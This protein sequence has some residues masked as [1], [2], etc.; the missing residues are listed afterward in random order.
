MSSPLL[1]GAPVFVGEKRAVIHAA[2]S[3]IIALA[4]QG[5]LRVLV[6]SGGATTPLILRRIALSWTLDYT[7]T[8]VVSDER[9]SES[10]VELNATQLYDS[11]RST[12]L[13]TAQIVS[14]SYRP[15]LTESASDWSSK[16]A[17]LPLPDAAILSMAD[18][19]HIASLFPGVASEAVSDSVAICRTS[20]KPP[21]ERISLSSAYLR[22][23][24]HRVAVVVGTNKAGS[25]QAVAAGSELPISDFSPTRWF[26][27]SSA[28][29]GLHH[30]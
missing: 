12:V 6:V 7:P 3:A 27:D 19:G 17:S 10:S 30:E 28:Y 25:L 23:I 13:A 5:K 16:L 9:H 2:A 4:D 22:K 29:R 11:L 24:P 18:D 21:G 20:P 1:G 8:L 15:D 14:P 26:V